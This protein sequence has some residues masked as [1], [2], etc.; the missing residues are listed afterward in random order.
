MK[1]GG[2]SEAFYRLA[3]YLSCLKNLLPVY[4]TEKFIKNC[5]AV[6]LL[7]DHKEYRMF[8]L[9]FKQERYERV[10]LL[11]QFNSKPLKM[12]AASSSPAERLILQPSKHDR[13]IQIIE[14]GGLIGR[15]DAPSS[16]DIHSS[17]LDSVR[18]LSRYWSFLS[19]V[20][21]S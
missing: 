16:C 21:R 1:I 13:A 10:L 2:I 19:L 18:K 6:I 9:L 15:K 5:H 14:A 11:L 8:L 3:T 17:K 7:Q 20:L 4:Q 12:S